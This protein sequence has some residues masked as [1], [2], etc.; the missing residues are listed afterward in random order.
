MLM[1]LSLFIVGMTIT[2]NKT[3]DISKVHGIDFSNIV[4]VDMKQV[5]CLATNIYH[6]ARKEP[7]LGQYAVARVVMNR[8]KQGF[9]NTPCKVVYQIT[10]QKDTNNKVCQFSWV[11]ENKPTPNKNH[12]D[13]VKALQVAYD[14]M[15][16]DGHKDI[17]PKSAVFFHALHVDPMWPYKKVK[18]IG[19][20]IFYRK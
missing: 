5:H 18:Q 11:C 9:A 1:L 12:P 7:L 13:Y 14:V 10:K 6:E 17:L 16:Y 4:K 3:I 15:A 20:H 8:V 2:G 19:N